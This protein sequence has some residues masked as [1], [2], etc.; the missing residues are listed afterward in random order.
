[1]H[2][3]AFAAN[4]IGGEG[5]NGSARRG[6]SVG[7][8]YD[9]LVPSVVDSLCSLFCNKSHSGHGRRVGNG[10]MHQ[11]GPVPKDGGCSSCSAFSK[12]KIT[13]SQTLVKSDF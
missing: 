8:I 5:V 12:L 4:R 7:P 2:C 3:N 10:A 6:R 1:M 11:I 13:I 9:C